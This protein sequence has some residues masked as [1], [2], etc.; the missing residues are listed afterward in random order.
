MNRT[1]NTALGLMFSQANL[2][3]DTGGAP[4]P[5]A[6]SVETLAA[7]QGKNDAVP[8]GRSWHDAGVSVGQTILAAEQSVR[9]AAESEQNSRVD[10][11]KKLLE[12][13]DVVG[14]RQ[15]IGGVQN[16]FV[17]VSPNAK[18][19]KS[20][21]NYMSDLRR[22]DNFLTL[23]APAGAGEDFDK[24]KAQSLAWLDSKMPANDKVLR[25]YG[26]RLAQF[27]STGKQGGHNK[28]TGAQT[29]S[30]AIASNAVATGTADA[31]P[32]TPG[33]EQKPQ[34]NAAQLSTKPLE[35]GISRDAAITAIRSIKEAD[36]EACMLEFG[37]RCKQS[38]SPV[39][40]SWGAAIADLIH[41]AD[42]KIRVEQ[43]AQQGGTMPLAVNS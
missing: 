35:G 6:V 36:I 10:G 33:T 24:A 38:P 3:T 17:A 16:A 29:T 20:H 8:A 9:I 34:G 18:L 43:N 26:E 5:N 19:I 41:E 25:P 31:T 4:N 1:L 15:F 28:G 22:V 7:M 32:T 27:P 2:G 11:L 42:E 39:Y 23:A 30:N 21:Q 37:N 14:R 13:S 40:N 12:V